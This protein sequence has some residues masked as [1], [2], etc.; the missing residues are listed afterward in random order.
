MVERRFK[1]VQDLTSAA[2][3]CD[4]EKFMEPLT[5]RFMDEMTILASKLCALGPA[6]LLGALEGLIGAEEILDMFPR[7]DF[8]NYGCEILHGRTYLNGVCVMEGTG[9]PVFPTDKPDI[10]GVTRYGK[11]HMHC[12]LTKE[13]EQK[14]ENESVQV[15]HI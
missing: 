14:T 7:E 3:A 8:K 11:T 13:T 2:K 1:T 5:N 4:T 6:M 9:K 15:W 12:A 10:T